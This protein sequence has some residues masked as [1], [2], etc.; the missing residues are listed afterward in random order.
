MSNT[1]DAGV[2]P[3]TVIEYQ[4]FKESDSIQDKY[5]DPVTQGIPVREVIFP[6][7]RDLPVNFPIIFDDE[8]EYY[9]V[10]VEHKNNSDVEDIRYLKE[11]RIANYSILK[12]IKYNTDATISLYGYT[13]EECENKLSTFLD[14]L[15]KLSSSLSR[16][17]ITL[18]LIKPSQQAIVKFT[19]LIQKQQNKQEEEHKLLNP[20]YSVLR[21]PVSAMLNRSQANALFT[22]AGGLI[23][24]R[25]KPIKKR[26]ATHKSK[27]N[28]TT[29][30][31]RKR[32]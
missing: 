1:T 17:T 29:T 21:N 18:Y 5:G 6:I 9:L 11:K 8:T 13:Y 28:K 32:H 22:G 4:Q 24:K 15:R 16:G 3:N 30:K 25:R 31:R 23:T 26:R 20:T 14:R 10:I 19:K 2:A 12:G 7:Y 27:K